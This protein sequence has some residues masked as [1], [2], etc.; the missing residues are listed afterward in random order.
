MTGFLR[1][2]FF[3][4]LD[5]IPLFRREGNTVPE[6]LWEAGFSKPN[7]TRFDI[8]SEN[9][10]DA[11]LRG[12]GL[13]IG[14]KKTKCLAWVEGTRPYRN[15]VLRARLRL[16]C[17]G[18]YGAAGI[19]F[20]MIDRGTYYLAL[21]SSKGYFRLDAV[22]NNMPLA[23]IGWT[24][25]EEPVPSA[26]PC[27]WE[28]ELTII[29]SGPRIILLIN[30]LWM[31]EINDSSIDA[32]SL[33]FAL[34][35][36]EAGSGPVPETAPGAAPSGAAYT[37]EAFL[38]YLSVDTRAAEVEA[39]RLAWDEG[40]LG[41]DRPAAGEP[42]AEPSG[43]S[44]QQRSVPQESRLRLAETFAAMGENA[45]ALGQLKKLRNL[46]SP[47]DLLLAA[48]LAQTL[49][50]YGEAEGYIDACLAWNTGGKGGSDPFP[51]HQ[52]PE[53]QDLLRKAA[54]EKAKILYAQGRYHEL[55]E[56]L[57]GVLAEGTIDAA[58]FALLGHAQWELGNYEEAAP[59]YDRAF[60]LDRENGLHG[61]NAANGYQAL[62]RNAEAL[63]RS[64]AAGK[65]FLRAGN[66]RD[67]GVLIPKLLALGPEHGEARSLAGKWAFGIEDWEE[68][69]REFNRAEA[70]EQKEKTGTMEQDPALSY[71]RALLLIR[72]GKRR[73][74]LP[75]LEKAARLAPDYG[76]FRFRLAENRYL[77]DNNPADPRL[78]ADLEKALSLLDPVSPESTGNS[79][80]TRN[81]GEAENL[82]EAETAWGW[83]NNLAAQVSLAAGDLEAAEGFLNRA[84]AALG[85]TAP[86][87][88][89]RAVHHYLRGSLDRALAVLDGTPDPG[90]LMAN[91]G[92]NLLVRTGRFDQADA[93]YQRAV[94][95]DP[96]NAEFLL[97]RASCLIELDRYGEAD[98]LLA[99]AHNLAPS[100]AVLELIAYVAVK[101]GEY[102]RAEAACRA[103][104]EMDGGSVPSLNS[105]GWIYS[106]TGRWEEAQE[107]L[108]RLEGP[109]LSGEDAERREELRRRILDGTTR[110]IPCARCGRTWRIPMDPP[111]VPFLRLLA[112]PPDELPA[113]TCTACGTSYCIGCAKEHLDAQGRFTCPAC[114]RPLKLINEGLKKIVADWAAEALPG[115]ETTP[116]R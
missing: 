92:G 37:A 88:V 66:Y 55:R 74:A 46:E 69:E 59:A 93:Y 90:G 41:E 72:K 86:V 71:L 15:M 8:K 25:F 104:L 58:L 6:E 10:Y 98:T 3:R 42:G 28:K 1:H 26:L 81:L 65:A 16:D 94:A 79:G 57:G 50:L 17:K 112:M 32:G 43:I 21:L 78:R 82:S 70:L 38:D 75:L 22:R 101:K 68:A 95:T 87:L 35:S 30:G 113:G 107:I 105:L 11:Y 13:G 54:V 39:A 111:P 18:G 99:R 63:D 76:L 83:T 67:L 33:G 56:Y 89:N 96:G 49:D 97:N 2:I 115:G 51:R 7:R 106:S 14:L 73:E 91:C 19:I 114:G 62:G 109:A 5:R 34:A 110:L 103:A 47:W 64:L 23:L 40:P 27:P 60:E 31:G 80:K 12:G 36:Y 45:A 9:T 20:R 108:T 85:E 84:S 24:E 100:P 52:A 48:R 102:P 77:L 29:A 116:G 61:V 44:P 4:V 53:P